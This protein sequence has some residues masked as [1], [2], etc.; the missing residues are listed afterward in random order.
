MCSS[1]LPAM[2]RTFTVFVALIMIGIGV[3]WLWFRPVE[4]SGVEQPAPAA[5]KE[6]RRESPPPSEESTSQ[7]RAPL[8]REG[9]ITVPVPPTVEEAQRQEEE[10][11]IVDA[12]QWALQLRKASTSIGKLHAIESG[13]YQLKEGE[14]RPDPHAEYQALHADLADVELPAGSEEIDALMQE[15]DDTLGDIID[16]L[17]KPPT[18]EELDSANEE[19]VKMNSKINQ[20]YSL[21]QEKR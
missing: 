5:Q 15:L 17:S 2:G 18:L 11:R 8:E 14:E 4:D 13:R 16:G 9:A 3:Y 21:L 6:Q 7:E 12:L 20:L 19:R 10:S 1:D